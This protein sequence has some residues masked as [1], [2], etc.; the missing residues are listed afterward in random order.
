MTEAEVKFT[1]LED[2][3]ENH[4]VVAVEPLERGYGQTLGNA[5]RR[6]MLAYLDGSAVTRMKVNSLPHEFSPVK[7][8][9]ED[10]VQLVQN[11]KGINFKMTS[12]KVHIVTLQAS[13]EGDVKAGDLKC[14]AGLEVTNPDHPIATLSDKKSK[15]SLELTVEFGHGY[16]L[17]DEREKRQVG[18]ILIDA[19]FS[20]VSLVSYSVE[21]TRVGRASNYDRLI[22]DISTN[23]SI[24]PVDAIKKAAAILAEKFQFI[25]GEEI[26]VTRPGD[27]SDQVESDTRT[28]KVESKIYLEELN[29]PTRVLNTI[30]KAGYETVED[31]QNLSEEDFA[32]IKNIGP[33]TVAMLME[34]VRSMSNQ[35]NENE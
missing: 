33:K 6:V 3:G 18:T 11:I 5:L 15:L 4:Q 35:N 13:G 31:L 28:P 10:V 22:M 21:S 12:P 20:P 24:N 19:N 25:A 27:G 9:S 29:L 2:L 7:G 26:R 17:P 34:K 16:R 30:K 32:K 1:I 23:G 14:P 8:V